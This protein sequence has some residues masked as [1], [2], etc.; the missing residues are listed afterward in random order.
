MENKNRNKEIEL[1]DKYFKELNNVRIQLHLV[2]CLRTT[3]KTFSVQQGN[4]IELKEQLRNVIYDGATQLGKLDLNRSDSELIL[5][6]TDG[7]STIGESIPQTGSTP[8]YCISSDI[9]TDNALLKHMAN[10]SGGTA[11]N[12][13]QTS[14]EEAATQL[15]HQPYRLLSANY[16]THEITDLTFLST[17]ISPTSGI[18]VTGKLKT[19]QAKIELVF[20]YDAKS[21]ETLSI[22]LDTEKQSSESGI[23]ER[24]WATTWLAALDIDYKA[25]EEEITRLAKK[26]NIVTRTTSL[27]VLDRVEDYV[28]YHITPPEELMKEYQRLKEKTQK[29][30]AK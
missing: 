15:L 4:W 30:K 16:N 27:I 24:L 28:K 21:T 17:P 5:F 26:Y 12:L 2:N 29:N 1:L 11:I 7:I 25:N 6:F 9:G 14:Y 20:G 19:H 8:I 23:A 18:G 3:T 13:N 10:Q 22:V